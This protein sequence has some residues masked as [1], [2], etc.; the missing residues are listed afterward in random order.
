MEREEPEKLKRAV[1]VDDLSGAAD[2]I[3][4]KL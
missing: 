4:K 2:W 3:L 1:V